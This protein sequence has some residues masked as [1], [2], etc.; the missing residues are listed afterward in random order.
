MT[1]TFLK[2]LKKD[3]FT[4]IFIDNN[5]KKNELLFVE[6][7]DRQNFE[8]LKLI[9]IFKSFMTPKQWYGDIYVYKK[10]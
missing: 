5:L 7:Q 6:L 10:L 9:K 8:K 1:R 4:R 3:E 2:N